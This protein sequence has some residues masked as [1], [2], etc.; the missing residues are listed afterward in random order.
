MR[1]WIILLL[2]LPIAVASKA[3]TYGNKFK[4]GVE[5]GVNG[6]FSKL[7]STHLF[8]INAGEYSTQADNQYSTFAYNASWAVLIEKDYFNH[9]LW[10]STGLSYSKMS[11]RIS[12]QGLEIGERPDF[13]LQ[14]VTNNVVKMYRV[15]EIKQQTSYC[16]V[17][18]NLRFAPYERQNIQGYF[19]LGASFDFKV[20]SQTNIAFKSADVSTDPKEITDR[21]G[22]PGIFLSSLSTG[23]GV[24]FG[25]PD[26]INFRMEAN[27]PFLILT[28]S[29]TGL[30]KNSGG[31]GAV[32][33]LVVPI[34]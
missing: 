16:G 17:P 22:Q 20:H 11:S 34:K 7:N 5:T 14:Y 12:R 33:N 13:Y 31:I 27:L 18:I 23:L 8:R 15:N 6:I 26:Q 21:F 24:N 1:Q 4:I 19:K 28:P 2:I 32:F 3:Q 9:K 10:I 30:T 25:A 29:A